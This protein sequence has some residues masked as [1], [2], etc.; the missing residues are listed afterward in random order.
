[1]KAPI[2]LFVYNR[3][4]RIEK[5]LASLIQNPECKDTELYIFSDGPKT[6]RD[7]VKV[8]AV[9]EKISGLELNE[10]FLA[11]QMICSEKNK[12]LA[13]A[14]ISGIDFVL[15]NHDRV[16]VIEDDNV[17]A[18]D[19][20]D[21]MN[22]GL[23]YYQNNQDVWAI[24][25][26]S[27][28]M[29]FPLD[30]TYDIYAVQRISSYS[31]GTW[32]DRWRKTEWRIEKYYPSFFWKREQRRLFDMYGEDRSL[33]LDAQICGKVNSWAIR[34]DFSMLKNNM[35]CIAPCISRTYCTGNDGS[36]THSR[37]IVKGFEANL[38]DGSRKAIFKDV[39]LREDIRREFCKPY[40]NSWK[41]RIIRNLDFIICYFSQ[42]RLRGE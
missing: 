15:E 11:V 34:F 21:Y 13:S 29:S 35:Y 25:A 27:R 18:S 38:S 24:N 6:E 37:K 28:D 8:R 2:V 41:R 20:L 22:R 42:Y 3:A 39:E 9:R 17:V 19:F 31:W 1:M 7:E 5:L 32:A 40:R 16:I 26:F 30:Y 33:M 12:G 14:I 10:K 4:D 36:G 23:K